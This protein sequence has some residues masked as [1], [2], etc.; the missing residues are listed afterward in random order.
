MISFIAHLKV[1]C[2]RH[3][4]ISNINALFAALSWSTST[5]LI[6]RTIRKLWTSC[7]RL[8]PV[9]LT[10]WISCSSRSCKCAKFRFAAVSC[11]RSALAASISCF[12]FSCIKVSKDCSFSEWTL[13]LSAS[14]RPIPSARRFLSSRAASTSILASCN[15]T[16]LIAIKIMITIS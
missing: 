4:S 13:S 3:R 8:F 6:S 14:C 9:K 12:S 5:R 10:V 15:W 7:S 2:A 1:S 16:N 11:C